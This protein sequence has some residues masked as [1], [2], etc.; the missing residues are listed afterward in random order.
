MADVLLIDSQCPSC[1]RAGRML[2]ELS[3]GEVELGS[4]RDPEMRK[5]LDRESPAD[6]FGPCSSRIS[7]GGYASERA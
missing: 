7:A 1:S 4:L 2:A 3:S 5:L 6:G